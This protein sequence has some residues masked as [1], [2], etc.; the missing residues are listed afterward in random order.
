MVVLGVVAN[1]IGALLVGSALGKTPLRGMDQPGQDDRGPDRRHALHA[2]VLFIVGITVPQRHLVA[3][4]SCLL[5]AIVIAVLAP[6]GDLTESMFK[7]NLDVKDFGTI[8][9]GHGGVLDR[10]DGF[11]FMLP[12]RV[13]LVTRAG[14][15]GRRR[16]SLMDLTRVAIAGSSGLDRHARP[17]TSSRAEPRRATRWSALGVGRRSTR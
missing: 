4:A 14:E 13:L 6:L 8:V 16:R 2:V 10:F 7:R 5:L 9:Q 3:P 11:L 12:A 17:S 1:D 15:L